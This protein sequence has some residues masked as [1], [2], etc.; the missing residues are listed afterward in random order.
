MTVA[1]LSDGDAKDDVRVVK[2]A[3]AM[4]SRVQ[5]TPI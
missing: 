3:M 5:R 4:V 1:L 2:M